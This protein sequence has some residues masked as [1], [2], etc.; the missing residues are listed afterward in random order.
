MNVSARHPLGELAV[1]PDQRVVAVAAAQERQHVPQAV[2]HVD[3]RL[4]VELALVRH[5]AD[6]AHR[7]PAV[8]AQVVDHPRLALVARGRRRRSRG[9]TG[10]IRS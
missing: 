3:A 6:H 8:L 1:E 2:E 7:Q 5:A 9:R 10:T 4:L